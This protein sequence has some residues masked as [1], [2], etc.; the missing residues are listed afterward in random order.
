MSGRLEETT[1][2][3]VAVSRAHLDVQ[4]ERREVAFPE[5][6]RLGLVTYAFHTKGRE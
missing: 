5:N 4:I 3:L 2:G 6:T 1:K